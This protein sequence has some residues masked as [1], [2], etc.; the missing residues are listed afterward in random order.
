MN[1]LGIDSVKTL[2]WCFAVGIAV[3][4]AYTYY[5][6][7]IVGKLVRALVRE[8]AYD[9]ESA[10]SLEALGCG[11]FIYRFILRKGQADNG[12]VLCTED[13]R[14][15]LLKDKADRLLAKHGSNEVSAT[16]YILVFVILIVVMALVTALYP[17]V[18][19]KIEAF[20]NKH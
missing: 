12:Y 13:R 18:A 16:S 6:K 9:G 5:V 8:E 11:G 4:A 3:A 20:L 15:Y 14:V 19:D 1:I 17:Y 10:K 7:G 2:I